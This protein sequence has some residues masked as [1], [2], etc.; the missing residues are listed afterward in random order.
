M[1]VKKQELKGEKTRK[2]W[3]VAAPRDEGIEL[4]VKLTGL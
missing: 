1:E 2:S 3:P 4:M